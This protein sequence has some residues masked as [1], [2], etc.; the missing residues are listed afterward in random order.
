MMM[1]ICNLCEEKQTNN[2]CQRCIYICCDD[3]MREIS[4]L[5]GHYK[6]PYRRFESFDHSIPLGRMIDSFESL[7]GVLGIIVVADERLRERIERKTRKIKRKNREKEV[8]D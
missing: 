8:K 7:I 6:C 4:R 2:K 3:C 1:K 5:N